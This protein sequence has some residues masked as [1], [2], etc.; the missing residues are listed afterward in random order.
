MVTLG[1]DFSIHKK[2]AMKDSYILVYPVT[3]Q[4]KEM[5]SFEGVRRLTCMMSEHPFDIM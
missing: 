1:I 4:Y 3:I 5:L 2:T